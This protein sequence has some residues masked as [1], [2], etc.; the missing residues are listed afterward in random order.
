MINKNIKPTISII[1]VNWNAG[2]QLQVC[3]DSVIQY[4]QS[5]VERIIVI[6]NGSTDD[7]ENCIK[8]I[9]NVTVILAKEN[10]GFAKACNLGARYAQSDYL[11]FLNPDAALYENTL[12]ITM[13][14]MEQ[15]EN[16]KVGIC[17]V[18][19][20][21]DKGLVDRSCARFPSIGRLVARATGLDHVIFTLGSAMHEWNHANNRQVDQVMGAFFLAR[22]SIFKELNGFDER[23]FV[24]YEEV[25]FSYRANQLGWVSMYLADAQAF[26][27]GGGTSN[28]IKARRLFYSLRSRI[29]YA[30]KHFN[31][32]GAI[33]VL[34]TTLIIEPVARSTLSICHQSWSSLKETWIAYGMFWHWL[35]E[36]ANSYKRKV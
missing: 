19:L 11:L 12:P 10:L 30:F 23:F 25:D 5:F 18:Q 16:A 32:I 6:D 26:H 28:Q 8:D 13:A 22:Q 2:D 24:Y 34:A 1:I 21:D 9:S 36:L 35:S 27:A 3:V 29:L 20:I 31:L 4:G 14:F 15:P 33:V 17:G 7:S